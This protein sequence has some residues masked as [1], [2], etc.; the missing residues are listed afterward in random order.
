MRYRIPLALALSSVALA[1]IAASCAAH[2]QGQKAAAQ[3]QLATAV[4]GAGSAATSGQQ[5]K[6]YQE[7]MIKYA[8]CMRDHGVD[9]PDPK[10]GQAIAAAKPDATTEK[11]IKACAKLMPAS[12]DMGD[13][14]E[15]YQRQVKLARCMREKGVDIADP[16]PGEG[17]A[18]PSGDQDKVLKAAR[19][20]QAVVKP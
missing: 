17:I 18:L 1:L 8:K 6:A 9:M 16:K 19:E 15:M 10:P 2:G 11:A 4:A 13:P 14:E 20:C 3:P 5:D 7:G 12:P